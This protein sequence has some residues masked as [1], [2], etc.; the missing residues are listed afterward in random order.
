MAARVTKYDPECTTSLKVASAT[1][2]AE[3]DLVGVNSSSQ[4]IKADCS[5][6]VSALGVAVR[7]ADGSKGEYVTVAPQ[8]TV[9]GLTSRTIAATEWLSTAGGIT[10]TRPTTAGY[11]IQPLGIAITATKVLY[12]I[13]PATATAQSAATTTLG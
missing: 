9:D 12:S 11:L 7:A 2:L 3:G 10:E 13:S 5:T 8:C 6:P 4:A 1:T